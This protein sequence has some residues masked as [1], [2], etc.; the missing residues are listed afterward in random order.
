MPRRLSLL[1][2]VAAWVA[3]Y[4]PGLGTLEIKGEEGRRILPAVSMLH[5]GNYLVPQVGSEPY[6]RK[7]PLVNWLVA[8]SF[9][10]FGRRDEWAARLPS[11]LCVLAVALAFVLIARGSLGAVGSLAGA[12]VWMTNLGVLEKGRLIE[13][14]ALYASLCGLAIV[15]WLS[16]FWDKR[17]PWLTW[18]VPWIFL[19]LGWLAKGPVHLVFF[20][21]VVVGVLWKTKQLRALASS[22]HLLGILVM[23]GIFAAWAIPCLLMM[24]GG[25]VA[26]I[27]SR[28]FSGRL[29]GEDFHFRGWLLNIPRGLGYFL[30][31]TLLLF[32][33]NRAHFA[34]PRTGA[35]ARGLLWGIALSFLGVN[36]LP[37]SLARYTM[38]LLAPAV[39][40]VAMLL[41]ADR[42]EIAPWL[43]LQRPAALPAALRWPALVTALSCFVIALYAFAFMPAL[44]GREKTRPMAAQIN[45]ALTPGALLYAV[46][47]DYQPFLFYVRD[48]IAYVDQVTEVPANARYL[49]VQKAREPEAIASAHWQPRQAHRLLAFKDY[50]GKEV[51][52]LQVGEGNESVPI[53][54]R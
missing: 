4:L 24:Q 12:L 5:T 17:S 28:Q 14:E 32:F 41:T 31:W 38:P 26:H 51:V 39:W 36:L 2:V 22:Q 19:G 43:N 33:A 45:A 35:I 15:C 8:G 18:I 40:L 27:W 29:S 44:K 20:Y 6:F 48:P 30:P 52:V 16:W 47:P 34:D 54:G 46:D 21:A 50:R 25:D 9:K 23:L 37:G 49:L 10:L 42:F 3:I 7:P 13:I 53:P 1:I 11:A